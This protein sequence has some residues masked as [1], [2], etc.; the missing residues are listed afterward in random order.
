VED[1][2]RPLPHL[3]RKSDGTIEIVCGREHLEGF[4]R[5]AELADAIE[6]WLEETGR[7]APPIGRGLKGSI[8]SI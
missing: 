4:K 6:K 3:R 7:R 2:H 1:A 8:S 5:Y